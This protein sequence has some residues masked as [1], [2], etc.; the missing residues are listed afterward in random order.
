MSSGDDGFAILMTLTGQQHAR[1]DH[2]MERSAAFWAEDASLERLGWPENGPRIEGRDAVMEFLF[3]GG[4][5]GAWGAEWFGDVKAVKHL[6]AN[7]YVR[8]DGDRA[9]AIADFVVLGVLGDPTE[10]GCVAKVVG[11]YVDELVKRDGRWLISHRAIVAQVPGVGGP[12][13]AAHE[14]L[15]AAAGAL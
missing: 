1:D 2:D 13:A 7:P 5:A 14:A 15:L 11:R 9:R 12:E 6:T 10:G 4:H 8:I 3:D